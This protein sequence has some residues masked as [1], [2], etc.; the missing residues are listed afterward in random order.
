LCSFG[1]LL[2]T[3]GDGT[4]PEKCVITAEK[5]RGIRLAM[6]EKIIKQYRGNQLASTTW[7]VDPEMRYTTLSFHGTNQWS[8]CLSSAH[9]W[10]GVETDW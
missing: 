1:C 6:A 9:V 4:A 8:S 3:G 5:E 7:S 2:V 10:F